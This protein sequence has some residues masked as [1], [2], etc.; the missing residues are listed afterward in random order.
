METNAPSD[1]I[2]KVDEAA[3]YLQVRPSRIYRFLKNAGYRRS[4]W[5]RIGASAAPGSISG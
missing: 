5:L 1:A 3:T 4:R 2:L